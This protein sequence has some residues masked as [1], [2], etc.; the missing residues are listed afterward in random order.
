MGI[1]ELEAKV[2]EGRIRGGSILL[3]VHV[4]S[5]EERKRAEDILETHGARDIDTTSE[6]RVRDES[7]VERR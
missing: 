5:A 1:P 6:A 7:R 3:A 2:Y 4:D